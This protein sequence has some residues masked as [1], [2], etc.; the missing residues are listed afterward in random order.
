MRVSIDGGAYRW[1]YYGWECL[2][3]RVSTDEST[4]GSVDQWELSS[5][6]VL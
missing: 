3:M 2:P 4:D 5:I 6:V 1:E